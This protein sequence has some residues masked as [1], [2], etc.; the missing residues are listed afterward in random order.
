MD[1]IG[2]GIVGCGGIGPLHAEALEQVEDARLAAVCDIDTE[3]AQKV[4]EKHDCRWYED[5]EQLLA[6]DEV[7]VVNICTPSGMHADMG[8]QAAQAGKHV[9][10]EKPL[11]V[12]LDKADAVIA[13]CAK[14]GV[15]LGCIFQN[16]FNPAARRIKRAIEEGKFGEL[17][18]GVADCIW[19]RAQSYYDSGEWR[20]TWALDRG[21]LCNQGVHFIDQLCWFMG[22]VKEVVSADTPTLQ[23]NIESEDL[24]IALL[25]FENG[26]R[27]VIQ[28]TTLAY[29]GVSGR[30]VVCGTTG[31]A[32]IDGGNL[33]MFRVE[34]EEE[35][36]APVSS[37]EPGRATTAS[38]PLANLP[39]GH[40]AQMIDMI[41]AIR[42]DREPTVNGAEA[43][44][45]IHALDLI[46]RAA[47]RP[48]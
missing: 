44:R 27:G 15:K 31:S 12:R 35:K 34:G 1:K 9:L 4:A 36:E 7:Q 30:V 46:Y 43:R 29:P 48:A 38:D 3:R 21:C 8:I 28:A 11:D 20:G 6:D 26:A 25:R 14:A 37:A 42:D 16:R 33:L 10:S 40:A 39:T 18:L 2:F 19:Y 5:F 13:A 23:R 47:G 17:V 45:A 41:E 24:G 32:A 22:D